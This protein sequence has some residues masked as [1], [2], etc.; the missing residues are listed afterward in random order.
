MSTDKQGWS[1]ET[2]V[3]TRIKNVTK[4]SKVVLSLLNGI[5]IGPGATLDLRTAFRKS[6]VIDAAH[7]IASLISTGHL[8]DLDA[9]DQPVPPVSAGSGAPSAAELQARMRVSKLREIS[10]STSMSSLSDWS[11]DKDTE[12]AKAATLRGQVL[13]GLR[14]DSGQ[15]IPGNEEET[16][17]APTQMIRSPIG[18][19]APVFESGA[20]ATAGATATLPG[21]VAA[22]VHRA[23]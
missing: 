7:E 15:V 12:V 14:D 4:N 17:A 3:Y 21:T 19:G 6:Q 5:E 2:H 8:V 11:N 1:D 9:G 16:E 22:I 13:M 10:D 23:E 20:P 18:G